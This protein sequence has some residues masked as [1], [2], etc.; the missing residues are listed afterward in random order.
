MIYHDA[1]LDLLIMICSATLLFWHFLLLKLCHV[2]LKR[3]D[4]NKLSQIITV[5]ALPIAFYDGRRIRS[6]SKVPRM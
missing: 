1:I 4:R 3:F 6:Y 2:R 5:S